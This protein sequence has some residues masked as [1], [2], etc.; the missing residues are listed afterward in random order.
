[1]YRLCMVRVNN[2][3][4]LFTFE[5][6]KQL[7]GHVLHWAWVTAL[8]RQSL[9][10]AQSIPS[11]GGVVGAEMPWGENNKGAQ[12]IWLHIGELMK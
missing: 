6:Y 9:H 4:D 3:F 11:S 1:M 12:L 8:R 5:S 10:Q 2:I 7:F